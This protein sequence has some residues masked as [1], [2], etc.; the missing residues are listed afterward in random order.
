M[1]DPKKVY[2]LGCG[3]TG[4]EYRPGLQGDG[5]TGRNCEMCDGYGQ[6]VEIRGEHYTL[7]W[8]KGCAH[9]PVLRG[10]DGR[11]CS[12]PSDLHY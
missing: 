7:H 1:T 5:W 2:C 6:Y 3:G 9:G 11:F 12:M 10:P 8:T 4:E